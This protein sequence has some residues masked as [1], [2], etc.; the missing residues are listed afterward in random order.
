MG[1]VS[2]LITLSGPPAAGTSTLAKRIANEFDLKIVNG[3]EIFRALAAERGMSLAKFTE[4]AEDNPEIDIEVDDRLKNVIEGHLDGTREVRADGLLVESRLA[5]WHADG[6]ADLAV[7]LDAP[8]E[9]RS[10]RLNERAETPEQL[11]KRERSDAH[12]YE[13]YYGIDITELSVYD[14]VVNTGT[15]SEE[16]MVR[17]V[18]SAIID[19]Q[20]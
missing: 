6:Q 8:I 7:W 2:P 20:R 4:H 19:I 18:E 11:R 17:T 13:E 10:S 14:L 1:P 16:G 9:I 12:R 5:G 15:L 3:G